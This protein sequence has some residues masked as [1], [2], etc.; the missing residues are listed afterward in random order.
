M[1][2]HVFVKPSK[3]NDVHPATYDKGSVLD[4][5]LLTMPCEVY[6]VATVRSHRHLKV[7]RHDMQG[8][9]WVLNM[10]LQAECPNYRWTHDNEAPS[11]QQLIQAIK[12]MKT[13]SSVGASQVLLS[14]RMLVTRLLRLIV[15]LTI[16]HMHACEFAK[17]W[18]RYVKCIFVTR[19]SDS[20]GQLSSLQTIVS[21]C[22]YVPLMALF[23][24]FSVG[25]DSATL[26]WHNTT[27]TIAVVYKT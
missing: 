21:M 17:I 13:A 9:V 18:Q 8:L 14:W 11:S 19:K 15:L 20:E 22:F 23:V 7:V 4:L 27:V 3:R 16:C 26:P 12:F 5:R 25:F 2:G 1:S 10:Y 24:L 6:V